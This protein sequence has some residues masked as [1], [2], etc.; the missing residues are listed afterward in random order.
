MNVYVAVVAGALM[1]GSYAVVWTRAYSAGESHQI[2]EQKKID[3]LVVRVKDE[4]MQGAATEIAKITVKNTTIMGRVQRE[5]QTNTVYRECEHTVDGLRYVND[6]LTNGRG[7]G[8]A[9]SGQL[10]ASDAAH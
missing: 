7:T 3:D 8:A 9:P 2:A 6:A 5:I 1:L 4:A 10:S